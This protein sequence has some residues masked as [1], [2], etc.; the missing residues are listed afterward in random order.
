MGV[1]AVG[2][3][4]VAHEF[5]AERFL[6]AL[7][8][9]LLDD[10]HPQHAHHDFECEIVGQHFKDAGSVVGSD[11]RQNDGDGLRIFIL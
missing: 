5:G 10:F 7:Q 6:D 11:L 3:G 9:F 1:A 4:K 2:S 8:N